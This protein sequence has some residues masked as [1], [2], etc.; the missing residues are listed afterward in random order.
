M[1]KVGAEGRELHR[2]EIGVDLQMLLQL[3]GEIARG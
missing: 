2:W 1:V 3:L